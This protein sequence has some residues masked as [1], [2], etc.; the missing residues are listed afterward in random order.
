[1]NAA[2]TRDEGNHM[3]GMSARRRG[4]AMLLGMSF[5]VVATGLLQYLQ[6]L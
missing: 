6:V 3:E 1:M 4:A 5:G 2:T